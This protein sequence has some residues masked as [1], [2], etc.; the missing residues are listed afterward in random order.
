MVSIDFANIGLVL[1]CKF[2]SEM[3]PPGGN[4]LIEMSKDYLT[5]FASQMWCAVV[6]ELLDDI[7][8]VGCS[9]Y[10]H[11]AS[12]LTACT[13]IGLEMKPPA[14]HVENGGHRFAIPF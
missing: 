9:Q 6:L 14:L 12:P 10:L 3:P 1:L 7:E 8:T 5:D 2:A 13:C 11:S 4:D